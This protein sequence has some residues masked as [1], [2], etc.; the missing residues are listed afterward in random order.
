MEERREDSSK[1]SYKSKGKLDAYTMWSAPQ[2]LHNRL[3]SLVNRSQ[4]PSR[5]TLMPHIQSLLHQ[6]HF[7]SRGELDSPGL[8]GVLKISK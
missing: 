7:S 8:Q 6:H 2:P 3:I 5:P 4:Q 1:V